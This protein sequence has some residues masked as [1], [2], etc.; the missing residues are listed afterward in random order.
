MFLSGEKDELMMKTEIYMLRTT[1]NDNIVQFLGAFMENM[2]VG[3]LTDVLTHYEN[4]RFKMTEE[5]ML[6]S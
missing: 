4:D 1:V 5:C 6:I 3:C 2:D